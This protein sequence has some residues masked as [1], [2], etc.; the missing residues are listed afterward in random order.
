[1]GTLYVNSR[2]MRLMFP[3][4]VERY[5]FFEVRIL[6]VSQGHCRTLGRWNVIYLC[7]TELAR[8]SLPNC[9]PKFNL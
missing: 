5:A 8:L 2:A 7:A 6:N 9:C 1:M 4:K 3:E